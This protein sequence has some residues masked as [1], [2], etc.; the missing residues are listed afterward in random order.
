M[1]LTPPAASTPPN[2]P[3]LREA[4]RRDKT[5]LVATL[6]APLPTVRGIHGL[7]RKFTR[8]ADALLQT[9]WKASA[10]P[11]GFAL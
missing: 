11:P 9:L 2:L 10:L 5:A 6:L 4:Y 7:L 1:N 3:A 8:L